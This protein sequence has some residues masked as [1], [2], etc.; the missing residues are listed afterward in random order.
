LRYI[1][2]AIDERYKVLN[3]LTEHTRA[4]IKTSQTACT[5]TKR[6]GKASWVNDKCATAANNTCGDQDA[7]RLKP[8]GRMYRGGYL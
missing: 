8:F 1:N 7:T 5:K 3:Q 4:K 2:N 6:K